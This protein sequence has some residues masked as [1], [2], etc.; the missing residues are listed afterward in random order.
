MSFIPTID[1][2]HPRASEKIRQAS[3]AYG[4]FLIEGHDVPEDVQARLETLASD[5]FA[6]PLAEKMKIAM[7]LGGRAWRGFF[8]I[9]D[10]L[11]SGR[12]DLKEGIYFGTEISADDPRVR[13]GL[14]MHGPN[15]FP[16]D[17]GAGN[18]GEI[19][20]EK[21]RSTVLTY[22]GEL[23]RVGH[24]VVALLSESLGLDPN[25]LR[26]QYTE[27]PTVLFRI[28]HYPTSTAA[29]EGEFPWGVGEHTD[30]GLLTLL[31]QDDCGGLEVQTAT[32]A[33]IPVPPR[34][35]TFV[36]NL[37]DM[38]DFLTL[39]KYR[40][41]PHRVRNVSGRDRYSYPFFFDPGFSAPIEP[42][43]GFSIGDKSTSRWDAENLYRFRG[44]YGE[45]LLRKVARVFPDLAS[46][47][48][49]RS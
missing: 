34:P 24:A 6:R 17:D 4:F 7:P 28:F 5:F 9:G 25:Y 44:T 41:A 37:G 36:C 31:K 42:L 23:T 27:D 15:L 16:H 49:D 40:S 26:R 14:P 12:P 8:P 3:E 33:W 45:Y 11:T 43:P 32:G 22:L 2:R 30:Y 47:E 1:L 18:G 35:N 19:G 29:T 13:A 39:G 46:A 48:L 38:I 21:W 20:N 10:E